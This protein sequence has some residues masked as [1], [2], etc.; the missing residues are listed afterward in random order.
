MSV[1]FIRKIFLVFFRSG[2][3]EKKKDVYLHMNIKKQNIMKTTQDLQNQL[4]TL[5]NNIK[6]AEHFERVCFAY[7]KKDVFSFVSLAN[8]RIFL[9]KETLFGWNGFELKIWQV[10]HFEE[11]FEIS[12]DKK[13]D[14][15]SWLMVIKSLKYVIKNID[16]DGN[17]EIA[18]NIAKEMID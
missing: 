5:K 8:D 2:V 13:I 3:A 9:F 7:L 16:L 14:N 11:M 18:E 12:H 15:N 4:V 1:F 17:K 6:F 10:K